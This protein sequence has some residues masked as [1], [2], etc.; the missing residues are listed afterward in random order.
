M[1]KPLNYAF[2]SKEL[3]PGRH[4]DTTTGLHL[5]VKAGGRK[6]W[7]YRYTYNKRA[8][9]K[10][11]GSFPEMSLSDARAL[12][13]QLRASIKKGILPTKKEVACELKIEPTFREIATDFIETHRPKWKNAK[14]ADQWTNTLRD[15]AYPIIGN[16]PVNQITLEHILCIL[17]PIWS[18]K[19][20]TA[21]RLRGRIESI[22]GA[23]TV[24]GLRAGINPAQWRGHLEHILPAP[25]GLKKVKHHPA[26][27]YKDIH[28]FIAELHKKDC[29]SALALEFLIL[30]GVRTSEVLGATWS[31]IT[32]DVWIIPASRMKA[33][34]EHRVPLTQRCIEILTIVRSVYGANEFIFHKNHRR[35]SMAAMSSLL[36]RMAPE[37]TVHGFR[38]TFRDWIANETEHAGEV[39][40]M[41]LAHKVANSVEAS[42]RRG[43][44]LARRRRL[45]EDWEM[46][47]ASPNKGNVINFERQAA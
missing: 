20:E 25:R 3:P 28:S 23:A 27:P 47:C 39:A 16:L 4:F 11:L 6:Y 8:G 37:Y 35:M 9:E 18:K 5:Y 14:H 21:S 17:K 7:I 29:I 46:Y 38:S 34:L 32:E 43:N 19:T 15:Y 40:E 44:L 12:A 1:K 41:A 22:L 36:L 2:I 26:L 30:T 33:K 31:E 10:C 24:L 13:T 45:M 42:Y